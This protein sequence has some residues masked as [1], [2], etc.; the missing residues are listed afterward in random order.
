MF[1][2]FTKRGKLDVGGLW[3]IGIVMD[4]QKNI[5]IERTS[6]INHRHTKTIMNNPDRQKYIDIQKP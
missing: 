1:S 2:I 3:W 6:T 4:I 5:D